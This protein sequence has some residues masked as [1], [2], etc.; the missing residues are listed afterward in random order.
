MA[1]P[2]G[3]MPGSRWPANW[4]TGW[5]SWRYS[6]MV[7]TPIAGEMRLSLSAARAVSVGDHTTVMGGQIRV[8]LVDGMPS[9]TVAIKNNNGDW[10]VEV[11]L[12]DDPDIVPSPIF[13][14][15]RESWT[16]GSQLRA[17][18]TTEHTFDNPLWLSGEIENVTNQPGVVLAKMWEVDSEFPE[19][20]PEAVEG[21]YIFYI[22]QGTITK[23]V[24]IPEEN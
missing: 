13:I 18:I 24:D 22:Q 19:V 23:L 11:P 15:A 14:L 2:D 10:V 5:V 4:Q 6:D 12:S 9:P 17:L 20:P 3:I 16:G 21:E 8:P 1:E 7:G